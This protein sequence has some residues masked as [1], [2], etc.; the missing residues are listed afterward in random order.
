MTH[1]LPIALANSTCWGIWGVDETYEGMR[2]ADA[3]ATMQGGDAGRTALHLFVMTEPGVMKPEDDGFLSMPYALELLLAWRGLLLD[4]Q[5]SDGDTAL[6]LGARMLTGRNP[7]TP[8]TGVSFVL[9]H[10]VRAGA[11]PL[12]VNA[13]G[14]TALDILNAGRDDYLAGL[15]DYFQ[16]DDWFVNLYTGQFLDL[17]RLLEGPTLRASLAE[18][19]LP[20]RKEQGGRRRL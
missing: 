1:D 4:A 7:G 14:Q 15:E 20:M 10:I 6:M 16:G 3:L 2:F 18:L 19:D 9:A 13:Q 5:G 17:V 8:S 12:L 11:N